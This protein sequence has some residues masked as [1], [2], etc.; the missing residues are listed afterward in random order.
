MGTEPPSGVLLKA[1][2]YHGT[3]V[4]QVL[5]NQLY[6]LDLEDY[7]ITAWFFLQVVGADLWY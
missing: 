7:P 6:Y 4:K 1:H 3:Y 2:H 5:A